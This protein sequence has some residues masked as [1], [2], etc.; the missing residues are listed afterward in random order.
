MLPRLGERYRYLNTTV[1]RAMHYQALVIGS[2]QG[3]TPLAQLFAKA[4]QKTALVESTHVAG[5]YINEG[6]TPIKTVVASG[7]VAHLAKRAGDYGL[8]ITG[9]ISTDMKK[10]RQRKRD[11][12]ESFRSG[13]EKRVQDAGVDLLKGTASFVDLKTISV[14]GSDGEETQRVTADKIFINVEARPSQRPIPGLE[15]TFAPETILNSTSI[16]EL[17]TVPQHLVIIGGGY[18][19]VEFGQVFRRLGSEVT[20]LQRG[21]QLLAREDP[22]IAQAMLAILKEDGVKVHLEA[23]VSSIVPGEGG[24]GATISLKGSDGTEG[25]TIATHVLLA[26]GRTPNSDTLKISAA[27]VDVDSKGYIRVNDRLETNHPHIWA[28]GDVKG[29]PASLTCHT[30]TFGSSTATC[31]RTKSKSNHFP[32]KTVI[33]SRHILST[34]TRNSVMSVC[35]RKTQGNNILAT[36]QDGHHVGLWSRTSRAVS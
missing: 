3:G 21:R 2:G 22:E 16:L 15:Q 11:I 31:S 23:S 17:D 24:D 4:G 7:R 33:W 18:I 20:I 12:V 10:I 27:R 8:G 14:L 35:T 32:L 28:I 5:C 36:P 9:D 26:I 19:G 1:V 30:T 6:C 25:S 29:G 34:R 13:S